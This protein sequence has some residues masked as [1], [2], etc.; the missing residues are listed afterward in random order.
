MLLLLTCVAC[1][2]LAEGKIYFSETFGPGWE[3]RWTRSTWKRSDG[4]SGQ[5]I[6]NAGKWFGD[7]KEDAGLQ[8]GEDSKFFG[9]AASFPQFSNAGKELIIQY[10]AKYEQDVDCGGGYLKVGPPIS[11]LTDFGDPTPYNIMFGPDKCGFTKRTH[12]IFRNPDGANVLKKKDLPYKQDNVGTS[13]LYRLVVKPNN[14]VSVEVNEKKIYEGSLKDDWEV[15]EPREIDD[16]S[17]SKPD[18]WVNS[19][20]MDDPND[21]KPSNWVDEKRIPDPKGQ[22]PDDWDDEEDGEWEAPFMKNP[23]YKGKWKAKRISNP[24]YKGCGWPEGF[25]TQIS[26][27]LRTCTNMILDTLVLI[28][29]RSRVVPYLITSLYVMTPMRLSLLLKN[30]GNYMRWRKPRRQKQARVTTMMMVAM[31][32]AM[33]AAMTVPTAMTSMMSDLRTPRIGKS[34]GMTTMITLALITMA[35]M[36][37]LMIREKRMAMRRRRTVMMM[38]R[39]CEEEFARRPME[40]RWIGTIWTKN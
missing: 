3:N 18:D 16:P 28:F 30:G 27:R 15:L 11:D 8:T 31:M 10:Q 29:G 36:T 13:R 19:K 20:M 5:W 4:T 32:A 35:V 25:Q 9:I 39:R 37:S 7:E 17:D 21:Q 26:W 38:K 33:M 40:G 14:N 24:A 12:L 23:D 22:K 2:G 6:L 1:V 34:L